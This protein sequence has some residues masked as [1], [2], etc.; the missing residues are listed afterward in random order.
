MARPEEVLHIIQV[1]E[2]GKKRK[3]KKRKNSILF[4]SLV[5]TEIL[6]KVWHRR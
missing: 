3:K 5:F 1:Q 4:P 6:D 2:T